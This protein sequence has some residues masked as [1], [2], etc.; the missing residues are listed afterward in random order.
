MASKLERSLLYAGALVL[1]LMTG[2]T[3]LDVLMRNLMGKPIMGTYEIVTYWY[4][5][6]VTSLG[7]WAAEVKHDHISVSLIVDRLS[8]QAQLLQA[9]IVR[10]ITIAFLGVLAWFGF[11]AA[12]DDTM[13]RSYTGAAEIPVWPTRYFLPLGFVGFSL[14]VAAKMVNQLR[15]KN[16]GTSDDPVHQEGIYEPV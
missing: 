6:A 7:L 12:W 15:A 1:I 16:S 13:I 3:A 9:L 2:H 14:V 11:Q 4:M 5:V 8:P 10:A